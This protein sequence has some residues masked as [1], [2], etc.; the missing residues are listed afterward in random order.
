MEHAVKAKNAKN[1]SSKRGL[2]QTD[3]SCVSYTNTVEE[4]P[5]DRHDL[6]LRKKA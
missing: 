1:I 2:T 3:L 6:A 5:Y 4:G